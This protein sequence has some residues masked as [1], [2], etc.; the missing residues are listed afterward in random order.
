[1]SIHRADISVS[2]CLFRKCNMNTEFNITI[3]DFPAKVYMQIGFFEH[4]DIAYPL[5]Q[6][7][8]DEMHVF[9]CGNAVLN[10]DSTEYRMQEGDVFFVPAN[11]PHV[12]QSFDKGAKRIT[13][14]IDCETKSVLLK[15]SSLPSGFLDLLCKEIQEY[16]LTGKDGQLK[17][18]LSYICSA[19]FV[20][21]QKKPLTPLAN[22]ELI[23]DEFFSKNY[24]KNITLDDLAKEL[25]L[26]KKQV[27][28]EVQ[29]TTGNTFTKE[30]SKRRINA[31]VILTQTT[32]LPLTK[33]SALVGYSSY[34]G[35]YKAYRR[36]MNLQ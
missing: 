8:L 6:H 31:A 28:R 3:N 12:Y 10:C 29:R 34:C 1:M 20:L 2:Q 33:I 19:F 32:S 18:L 30:L 23:I 4:A 7:L 26:S 5:H 36:V 17:P 24:N 21:K 15:K 22:R 9:L 13:F 27:E 35:F 11:T 25:M 16:V 14:F